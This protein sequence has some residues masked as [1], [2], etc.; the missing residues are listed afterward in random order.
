M[1]PITRRTT[2]VPSGFLDSTSKMAF[3]GFRGA[4]EMLALEINQQR[5][6]LTVGGSDFF[7]PSVIS[8]AFPSL[9]L[10][11]HFGCLNAIHMNSHSWLGRSHCHEYSINAWFNS[12]F[13][14]LKSHDCRIII[15]LVHINLYEFPC[16]M[17]KSVSFAIHIPRI[18]RFGTSQVEDLE[19]VVTAG[20]SSEYW[21]FRAEKSQ[22]SPTKWWSLAILR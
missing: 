22:I 7:W 3:S 17:V 18:H 14:W 6:F 16:L 9:V 11:P 20:R 12:H 10:H 19:V 21:K 15:P 1:W 5:S 4:E 8:R 13:S 2:S